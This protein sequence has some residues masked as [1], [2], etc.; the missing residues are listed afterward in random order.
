MPV[1]AQDHQE[2]LYQRRQYEKG[3][4]GRLYWDYRDKIVLS[5]MD[6]R[7]RRVADIGCGEGITLEKIGHLFPEKC[8]IG[9]DG[10]QENLLI[11]RAHRLDV[12][13]GDLYDLPIKS[14]SV[15]CIL[16]LEVI[17][18]L[19]DPERAMVE[20]HRISAPRGKLIMLFPNDVMF[21]VARILTLRL[22]EAYY[23]PGHLAQWTP[24][25]AEELVKRHGFRVLEK[26]SI[27]FL[28][29]HF[30]LHHIVV[31]EKIL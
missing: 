11:C 9:V 17:E 22:K 10:L 25:S 13:G 18:H 27:P 4:I 19:D 26:R 16:F 31:C 14:E 12:L 30:S 3:G 21:K 7:D 1:R 28:F 5:W 29:W 23:D 2:P 15:D 6:G 8:C 24:K 20:I